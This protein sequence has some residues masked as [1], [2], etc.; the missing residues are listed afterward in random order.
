MQYDK[1]ILQT[2]IWL[3]IFKSNATHNFNFD[4]IEY[5]LCIKNL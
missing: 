1:M 2:N 3:N 4:N 5:K